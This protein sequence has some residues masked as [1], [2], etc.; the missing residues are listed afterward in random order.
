[1]DSG[2]KSSIDI[3]IYLEQTNAAILDCFAAGRFKPVIDFLLF[4]DLLSKYLK[5]VIIMAIQKL[6]RFDGILALN[7]LVNPVE[8]TSYWPVNPNGHV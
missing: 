4:N 6:N 8:R 5:P 3:S 2:V 1:L 7:Y